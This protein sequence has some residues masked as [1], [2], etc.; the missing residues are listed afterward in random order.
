M[1]KLH[2]M[3]VVPEIALPL[4]QPYLKL[5]PYFISP[6]QVRKPILFNTPIGSYAEIRP[7]KT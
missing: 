2:S 4:D 1:S 3:T 7:L 5:T 6:C